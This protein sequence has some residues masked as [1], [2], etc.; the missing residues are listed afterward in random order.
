LL[1]YKKWL[2]IKEYFYVT[3]VNVIHYIYISACRYSAQIKVTATDHVIEVA[4]VLDKTSF[5]VLRCAAAPRR[6]FI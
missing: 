2:G 6:A 4:H 3:G 1:K 5:L